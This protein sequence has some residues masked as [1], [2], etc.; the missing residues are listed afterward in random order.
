MNEE[1]V[2]IEIESRCEGYFRADYIFSCN[3]L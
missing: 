3:L 1:E 2:F